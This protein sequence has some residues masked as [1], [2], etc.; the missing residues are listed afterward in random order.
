[1]DK[2]QYSTDAEK[3]ALITKLNNEVL[4]DS[5]KMFG[6]HG[7]IQWS[8][9][10]IEGEE[11]QV[12]ISSSNWGKDVYSPSREEIAKNITESIHNKFPEQKVNAYWVE[13]TKEHGAGGLFSLNGNTEQLVRDVSERLNVESSDSFSS[14]YSKRVQDAI[15]FSIQVHEEPVK[16]KRKGKDIPYITH[17][18][19]VGLILSQAGASEDVVVAG[20]LHDTIEDCEPYG[21]VTK[22]VIAE[23]FGDKVASLVDSVTEKDKGLSWHERKELALEEIAAFSHD[24][25]LVKSGDVIS[26][27]TE[28]IRDYDADGEATFERFNASKEE[29]LFHTLQVIRTILTVW[30]E[31]PLAI[32]LHSI[33]VKLQTMGATYFMPTYPAP[34][35]PVSEYSKEMDISCPACGWKGTPE[36]GEVNTDS[37]FALDVSCPICEKMVL[38]AEYSAAK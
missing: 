14:V 2:I 15:H 7:N 23:K 36:E 19:T 31:N 3:Q 21:S 9:E 27:N 32:D 33:A 38:V 20:I 4:F 35:I 8:V 11:L 34:I 26:N 28:L 6:M 18:L 12:R 22:E 37:E 10:D 17:P 13:W 5:R 24:S 16:Q 25:L 1:M 30:S 29:I